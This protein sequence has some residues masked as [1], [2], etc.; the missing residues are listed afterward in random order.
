MKELF[1]TR[2]P[3]F[4]EGNPLLESLDREIL[5]NILNSPHGKKRVSLRTLS[6]R[7]SLYS[8]E[9][10][11]LY[12]IQYSLLKLEFMGLIRKEIIMAHKG[13]ATTRYSYNSDTNQWAL[14]KSLRALLNLQEDK[15]D[16]VRSSN[17]NDYPD[18]FVWVLEFEKQIAKSLRRFLNADKKFKK[19]MHDHL[20]EISKKA[21]II[22]RLDAGLPLADQPLVPLE[23][24]LKSIGNKA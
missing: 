11:G 21:D 22:N 7:F 24:L 10:I 6:S 3:S 16:M 23:E 5:F 8:G 1:F 19:G 2:L 12:R 13:K 17:H 14:Y 9:N 15:R 4:F 20:V 18:Q